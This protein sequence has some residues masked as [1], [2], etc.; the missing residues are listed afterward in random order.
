MGRT[1]GFTVLVC[2]A[3]LAELPA[4]AQTPAITHNTWSNG[5]AMPTA[6]KYPMTGVI[7]GKIH[8]IGGITDAAVVADN[9]V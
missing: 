9:Q 3:V 5:T 6:L 8:M 4:I 2:A 1:R 7:K